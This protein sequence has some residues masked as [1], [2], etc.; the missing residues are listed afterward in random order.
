[1]SNRRILI[2]GGST[3]AA[4][5]S[6]RRA[7]WEPVC[8]DLFADLDLRMTAEVIPVQNYPNSLPDDVAHVRAD[9]WFYC[10][11]LE[12]SPNILNQILKKGSFIGPL[13]GTSPD[14]LTALRNP[15]WLAKTLTAAGLDTLSVSNQSSPPEPDGKWLQKPLASAGGRMIRVWD[16][17]AIDLPF[18]EPHYFQRIATG[19]GGSIIFFLQTGKAEWIGATRELESPSESAAPTRF[20]YCGSIGPLADLPEVVSAKLKKMIQIFVGNVPSLN[21]IVGLDFRFDGDEVWLVEVNPRYTASVEVL[22]LALG[23]SFLN[24]P[25]IG[26][27][28]AD[29]GTKA[30]SAGFS[31]VSTDK[32]S[33]SSNFSQLSI[34]QDRHKTQMVAKQIL[35]AS[36]FLVAPN[37]R[38]F[39]TARDPWT[40]PML[41]DI[42]VPGTV[43]ERGWPICTVIA[44]GANRQD[45]ESRM[46]ERFSV[47]WHA[48]RKSP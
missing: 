8:A 16:K 15:D 35:Y 34:H 22:E 33:P 23:R 30:L 36:E 25:V 26:C 38:Q 2:V 47:V 20:S 10:G 18:P 7:G 40:I 12:N 31:S 43:I 46:K 9:G 32:S 24:P 48:L 29:D 37:L 42:P 28:F 6:V 13:M 1:M 5:D 41:A 21:G 3:R 14:A 19:I 4:A 39:A 44:T 11:A 45:L 17:T 27:H